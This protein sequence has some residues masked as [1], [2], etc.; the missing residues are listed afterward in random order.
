M[1]RAGAVGEVL[2]RF[3]DKDGRA[4]HAGLNERAVGIK[5]EEIEG[6]PVVAIAG[7]EDKP[8]AIMASLESRVITGLITDEA[9]A[10]TIVE[11]IDAGAEAGGLQR[12][13]R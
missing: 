3:L 12:A 6:K 10:K 1:K 11:T 4:V 13:K 5:L 2:G 8:Q 9:T 7:G